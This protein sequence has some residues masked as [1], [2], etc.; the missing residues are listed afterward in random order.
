M[1]NHRVAIRRC[2]LEIAH[3]YF[4]LTYAESYA[5]ARKAH[6]SVDQCIVNLNLES[7]SSTSMHMLRDAISTLYPVSTKT[8]VRRESLEKSLQKVAQIWLELSRFLSEE[9]E[10]ELASLA[11]AMHFQMLAALSTQ[12]ADYDQESRC[13]KEAL[14]LVGKTKN[15][16]LE[17][18]F[19]ILKSFSLA[20]VLESK[21]LWDKA[22]SEWMNAYV[23]TLARA[24]TGDAGGEHS[25]TA[26]LRYY[27][28]LATSKVHRIRPKKDERLSLE[29]ILHIHMWHQE[30]PTSLHMYRRLRKSSYE[31]MYVSVY[32]DPDFVRLLFDQATENV[33]SR[34]VLIKR[35]GYSDTVNPSWIQRRLESQKS[36]LPIF[37]L[38]VLCWL[39]GRDFSVAEENVIR[40]RTRN[41]YASRIY[42]LSGKYN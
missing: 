10:S 19:M 17:E 15:R 4:A 30:N 12:R 6:K 5:L 42:G 2:I 28:A 31:T 37:K 33:G 7:G 32:L 35:L 34:R 24:Q 22:T 38:R 20:E 18:R 23:A 9:S 14:R 27:R 41:K 8:T 36:G 3:A 26:R 1:E 39:A 25:R 13:L 11:K 29:Q 16:D 21:N 40:V